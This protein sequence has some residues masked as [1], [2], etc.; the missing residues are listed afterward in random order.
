M[1]TGRCLLEASVREYGCSI[2]ELHD[3]DQEY[4]D[5]IEW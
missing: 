2:H 4:P 5:E 3:P 1:M